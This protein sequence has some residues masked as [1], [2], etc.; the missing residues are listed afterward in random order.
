M[1]V[2]VG[3]PFAFFS[4]VPE[5]DY[6][7]TFPVFVIDMCLPLEEDELFKLLASSA[8]SE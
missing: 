7:D 6:T 1:N 3:C 5:V 4:A 2:Y 8:V